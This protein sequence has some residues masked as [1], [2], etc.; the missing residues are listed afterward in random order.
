VDKK[1]VLV[2][3]PRPNWTEGYCTENRSM[4]AIGTQS[5][6]LS[7]DGMLM[8]VRKGQAPPDLRYFKKAGN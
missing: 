8:P 6:F 2:P 4:I 5:Y 7:A 1:Y 3:N